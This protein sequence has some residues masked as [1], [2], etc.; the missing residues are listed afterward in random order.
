MPS[1]RDW[2]G[3]ASRWDRSRTSGFSPAFSWQTW[4]I[5]TL[6]SPFSPSR[7][8][9]AAG[10]FGWGSI[11][12]G[13]FGI[14]LTITGTFGAWIGGRLDDRIGSRAV[15]AGSLVVLILT[16]I[17]IIGT[18]R[19]SARCSCLLQPHL[20]QTMDFMQRFR[21]GSIWSLVS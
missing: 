15:I 9:Y 16:C 4:S 20:P 6:W 10:V 21:K 3:C 2:R 19:E 8:I 17:G 14:L 7:G 1:I 11:E 12:I 5:L 13:I 18:T